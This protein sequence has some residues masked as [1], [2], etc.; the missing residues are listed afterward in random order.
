MPSSTSAATTSRKTSRAAVAVGSRD[1]RTAVGD[2][3]RFDRVGSRGRVAAPR[4]GST[5]GSSATRSTSTS[6]ATGSS[7][8]S[9]RSAASS[10]PR[11]DAP[12]RSR[13]QRCAPA[14]S[15]RCAPRV[16][17][18]IAHET[19]ALAPAAAFTSL[20]RTRDDDI[21]VLAEARAVIGVG[22]GIAPD[23]YGALERAPYGA[24]RR[25]GRN[26]QGHRQGLDAA[27]PPDRH[28]RP[29]DRAAAVRQHRR[30]RQVQPHRRRARRRHVLA[31]NPDPTAPIWDHADVGIVADWHDAVPA[32]VTALHARG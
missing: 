4:C 25:A 5:P 21:D 20:A 2:P 1:R 26:P 3:H 31:I 10:S 15:R 27:C 11:S 9:P 22:T 23:E 8:G 29:V 13:W 28:H 32:L 19:I 7:R 30:E 6:K 14:C 24:R 12:R 18:A 17:H 16:A